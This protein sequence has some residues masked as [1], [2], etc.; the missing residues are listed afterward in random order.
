MRT[1]AIARPRELVVVAEAHPAA[2]EVALDPGT[3]GKRQYSIRD[4][5]WAS[6][7]RSQRACAAWDVVNYVQIGKVYI[8]ALG[9]YSEGG[10]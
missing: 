8:P 2:C 10:K 5:S 7:H 6:P 9:S 3:H 4:G 1:R